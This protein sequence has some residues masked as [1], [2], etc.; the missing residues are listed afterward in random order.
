MCDLFGTNLM[1]KPSYDLFDFSLR[2]RNDLQVGN[3]IDFVLFTR[4]LK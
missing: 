4:M 2:V 3:K 1:K